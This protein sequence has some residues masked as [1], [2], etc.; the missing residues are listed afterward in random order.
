M[1]SRLLVNLSTSRQ[2]LA[3]RQQVSCPVNMLIPGQPALRSM[4]APL[5]QHPLG[6]RVIAVLCPVLLRDRSS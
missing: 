3:L 4:G 2:A 6:F 5:K 1:R